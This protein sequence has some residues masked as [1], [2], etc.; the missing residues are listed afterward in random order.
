MNDSITIQR[1]YK[2]R[3]YPTDL[4]KQWL[5]REF[6]AA[7]FVYNHF[8]DVRYTQYKTTGKGLSYADTA[9]LLTVLKHIPQ[10]AWLKQSNAQVLQQALVNLDMAFNNFFEKRTK[11]PKFK[12]KR[13]RQSF[14]VPQAFRVEDNSVILPKM[15]TPLRFKQHRKWRGSVKSV[16]VSKETSGQYYVSFL[17]EETVDLPQPVETEVGIDLGLHSFLVTSA[18]NKVAHP[19]WLNKSS[20]KLRRLKRQ[21][22][23]TKKGSANREKARLRLARQE[24]R[25]AQQRKDFLHRLSH[26]LMDENQA[27]SIETLAVKNLMRNHR[28]ARSIA[29]SGWGEFVRQL[30][31]KAKWNG[32]ALRKAD[33]WFPP[34]QL[35]SCCGY[36]N[37]ELMLK[38][39]E[40]D[41]PSC[42]AHH[43]RDINAARNIDTAGRAGIYASGENVRPVKRRRF[44]RK[45]E[46][47]GLVP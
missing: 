26:Q 13:G 28:L 11:Y 15:K 5:E 39:R 2:Y 19:K 10:H 3:A 45:E 30:E 23:R 42:R 43:D 34:T 29:D 41:C 40:W 35:C 33:R 20:K 38:D 32:R 24:K 4:Q 18:G 44:S 36:R 9:K 8:L 16:T 21:H 12:S 7:R 1:G 22:A 25:V 14:R 47:Y 31:Y 17:V 6:G 27:V 37:T 46:A